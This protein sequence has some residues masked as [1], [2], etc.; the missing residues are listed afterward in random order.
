MLQMGRM[1]CEKQ[2][3]RDPPLAPVPLQFDEEESP[4]LEGYERSQTMYILSQNYSVN[5]VKT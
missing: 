1:R 2:K 3:K 4:S 5:E